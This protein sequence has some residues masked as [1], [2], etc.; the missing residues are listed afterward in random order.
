MSDDQRFVRVHRKALQRNAGMAAIVLARADV[1][2]A[3]MT[4][5]LL[6]GFN[7]LVVTREL[8]EVFDRIRIL[9]Q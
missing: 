5:G 1:V 9:Q 8:A 6:N 2:R 3:R 7:S 4:A